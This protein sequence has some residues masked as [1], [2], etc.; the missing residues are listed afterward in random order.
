MHGDDF[1]F[2][3]YDDELDMVTEHMK[4]WYMLKVRAR[5]GPDDKDEKEGVI[6]NRKLLWKDDGI[7]FE[8]DDKHAKII[9]RELGIGFRI[10][11]I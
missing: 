11:R 3:G 6:L 1:T 4:E 10:A 2:L 7:V 9:C 5:V 8:A